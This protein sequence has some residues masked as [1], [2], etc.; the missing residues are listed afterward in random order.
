MS[1]QRRGGRLQRACHQKG[2]QT[3]ALQLA[4]GRI[5]VICVRVGEEKFFLPMLPCGPCFLA[6]SAD[7]RSTATGPIPR[8][9]E[10]R[11]FLWVPWLAKSLP[12][13]R[14]VSPQGTASDG[15]GSVSRFMNSC[16]SHWPPHLDR[17]QPPS[18][19]SFRIQIMPCDLR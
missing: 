4:G 5:W 18:V 7:G 10:H 14:P 16:C 13:Q 12:G 6:R 1:S 8:R 11:V 19:N 15:G 3:V 9:G 2:A 17:Y